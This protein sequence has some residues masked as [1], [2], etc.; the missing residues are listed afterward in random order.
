MHSGRIQRVEY[1]DHIRSDEQMRRAA[2]VVLIPEINLQVL[3]ARQAGLNA[4]GLVMR[5]S[6]L[7]LGKVRSAS[8]VPDDLVRSPAG[9]AN[10]LEIVGKAVLRECALDRRPAHF[11]G[12][13]LLP[14]FGFCCSIT[15]A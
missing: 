6:L 10:R 1:P 15:W 5:C 9:P 13:A 14:S 11:A 7:P 3:D 4:L 8:V 2:P 12:S